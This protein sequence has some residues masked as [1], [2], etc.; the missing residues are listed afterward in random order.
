ML[1]AIHK[2]GGTPDM[3]SEI[4]KAIIG[5][6]DESQVALTLSD[7]REEDEPLVY[8]NDA[9]LRMTGYELSDVT[10]RNCRFLQGDRSQTSVRR[11]IRSDFTAGRDSRVIIANY[12]KTGEC[13][14]NYLFIFTIF[15]RTD[16]PVWRIGSQFEVPR[17]ER[18]AAFEKHASEL[19]DGLDR[20]NASMDVTRARLIELGDLVG[21]TVRDLL[22]ARLENLRL[23]N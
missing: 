12:R 11:T 2:R 22:R 3:T 14:D 19:H 7:P 16:A 17:L 6:F 4:P 18:A 10:G 1:R 15:D 9:F 8:A 20:I 21:L 5:F 13:F 23:A